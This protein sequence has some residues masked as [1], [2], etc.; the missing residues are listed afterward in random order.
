MR[1]SFGG[2]SGDT[3]KNLKMGPGLRKVQ[4][5]LQQF[6]F[7]IKIAITKFAYSE[8]QLS[9]LMNNDLAQHVDQERGPN[10]PW[11]T[12]ESHLA[13]THWGRTR[14]CPNSVG[15][16]PGIRKQR[17]SVATTH[18]TQEKVRN[19]LRSSPYPL[20]GCA[21]AAI[22][23]TPVPQKT[24]VAFKGLQ[25][26]MLSQECPASAWY[27]SRCRIALPRLSLLLGFAIITAATLQ[28][29]T[30]KTMR[31]VRGGGVAC[32]S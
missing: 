15:R 23:A 12:W 30:G 14:M 1:R 6:C 17:Q 31:T 2:R 29:S 28:L 25:Q 27:T 3:K 13:Q 32:C 21:V 5:W 10:L 8:L 7:F 4:K 19:F 26:I 22:V 16:Q 24:R 18:S 20:G 11:R 9:Q